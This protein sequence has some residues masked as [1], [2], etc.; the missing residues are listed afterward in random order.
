MRSIGLFFLAA[1]VPA[2]AAGDPA[3][4]KKLVDEYKCETCHNNKTYGEAKAVYLRKD[5]HVSS[6][7]KL[8][9]Q[10]SFCN[11]ELNLKLFPDDEE[12]IVAYLNDQ[13]Y[14]FNSS[15]SISK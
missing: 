2:L 5:R 7:R 12:H 15:R 1:A 6:L 4:G 8:R 3:E 14:R 9:T 11:T 13:Y 10:V